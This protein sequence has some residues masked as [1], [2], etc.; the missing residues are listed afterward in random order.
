MFDMIVDHAIR[1]V[2]CS[3]GQ[4]KQS[5]IQP[6][7]ISPMLGVWNYIQMFR[8]TFE[9]PTKADRYHVFQIGQIYPL[10]L[11]LDTVMEEWIPFANTCNKNNLF[12]D[13]YTG[14]G[15]RAPLTE[16]YYM[17]TRERN[18]ILAVREQDRIPLNLNSAPL[19]MRVYSNAF[20]NSSRCNPVVN[21]IN[22]VGE[23]VTNTSM[24]LDMQNKYNADLALPGRVLP[25][26]NGY[27]VEAINLF[28]VTPGDYVEVI[29]D[30]SIYNTVDF[31]LT[32]LDSFTST[33]DANA[34]YL[35]HYPGLGDNIIDYQ[36]DI[37]VYLWQPSSTGH[38]QGLYY[39]RNKPD[40]FRMVTHKDYAISVPYIQAFLAEMGWSLATTS[41]RLYLRQSGYSRP[42]VNEINR[43][44]EL[45]KMQDADVKNAMLGV[46][47]N[48]TNWRA[49]VLEA[50][51]YTQVMRTPSEQVTNAMVEA[52]YGYNTISM[53][54]GNTPS[55]TYYNSNQ[56]T[57]DVTYGL[58]NNSIAY[59]YDVNGFLL[60]YYQHY[61]GS[62]YVARNANAKLVEMISGTL[63][64][65]LDEVYG[66]QTTALDSTADYRFYKCPFVNGVP[67]NV[68]V[69]VTD[70][71]DVSVVGGLVQWNLDPTQWL[72]LVR[73]NRNVLSYGLDLEMTNGTL[74]FSLQSQQNRFGTLANWT[75]Q[76]P[77]GELDL[78][79]N[80]KSLTENV[81]YNVVFPK[82]VITNKLFLNDPANQTQHIDIRFTG[83]C[84]SDLTREAIPDT[85]FIVNGLLSDNNRFDIRDD[86][87]LR[88]T[89]GGALYDRSEVKF[90]ESNSGVTIPDTQNGLP[91]QI[92]DIVVPMRGQTADDTYTLRAAAKIIDQQIGDYLT[93][94]VPE[95][96]ESGPNAILQL[97]PV[98]SVFCCR[99]MFD[100][101]NGVLNDP[102]IVAGFTDA[103]VY[104][105]CK[106]YEYLL[107]FDPTQVA[108]AVDPSYVSIQPH[109]LTDVVDISIYYYRFL[110]RVIKLYLKDKTQLSGYVSLTV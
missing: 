68:W 75:M 11:G 98:V 88:I 34:K 94:K 82:I 17:V 16:S 43:I 55:F 93:L 56:L 76:I 103:D 41:V 71:A 33:L 23:R 53:L 73:G 81:D 85:G 91:Y 90:A 69:D 26:V 96:P 87:V 58:Q 104:A 62:S 109:H 22:V 12:V 24:I 39:H 72:T 20:Y 7:R 78:F 36:D 100:L 14:N 80:G 107:A 2:W 21:Y 50:S 42:L 83:F 97:Y 110:T 9:L 32:D 102:R 28:T 35:L 1:N 52:A 89:V 6:A 77:L 86:K 29:Y 31:A 19:F 63:G 84:Q 37:E 108:T 5:I 38:L 4:D 95:A 61:N 70:T 44:S 30:G 101:I 92:R 66:Q 48:V 105:I 25:Y 45:Y 46:S 27:L 49:E 99:I 3:P 10:L 57:V 51:G 54:L 64:T 8:R 60:G 67:N 13:I 59:E 79:L 47:S 40:G 15:A 106:P 18:V 74:E 65:A